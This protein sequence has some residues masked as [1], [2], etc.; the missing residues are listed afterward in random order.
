MPTAFVTG[1]SGF[2]GRHLLECLRDEG[3]TTTAMVR[4]PEAVA[5]IEAVGATAVQADLK[6]L[7]SLQAAIPRK[8]DVVFHAA[9]D[10]TPSR[11]ARQRQQDVNVDGTKNVI[12]ASHDNNVGRMV[13]VS[14]IAV[15]G[16]Q[17]GVVTEDS[18]Q[19]GYG[20][21]VGYV[22]TKAQAERRVRWAVER[23]LDAVICN[24]GH[25]LGRY[26]AGNWA[27]MF[28]LVRDDALP[29]IPP[30][31]GCFAN[32]R[33]VA[34]ALVK[35]AHQGRKGENYLLGG[36]HATFAEVVAIIGELLDKKVE[37]RVT[38]A[39]LIKA[40]AH[41]QDLAARV[42]GKPPRLTPE[43]AYFVCHDEE[44]SSDKAARELDYQLVP[45]RQ[46]LSECH[47]WLVAE[48]LL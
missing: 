39:P 6:S 42:T 9:A 28:H 45:V 11:L 10:T 27:R 23:G 13:H 4:R 41:L 5:A 40:M 32:G 18:P 33:E 8:C 1:A 15:Y 21:W 17:K 3:W 35:A 43:A 38:P 14:S 37:A 25:I 46:S 34:R 36:P 29:G 44:M 24:P 22:H 47:E 12:L 48:G 19:L 31:G 30:G 7:T 2:V 26:D 20:S 16:H